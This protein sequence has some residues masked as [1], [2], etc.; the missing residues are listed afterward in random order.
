MKHEKNMNNRRRGAFQLPVHKDNRLTESDIQLSNGV[1]AHL[2]SVW[3]A[4][5]GR[6]TLFATK[7]GEEKERIVGTLLYVGEGTSNNNGADKVF[8]IFF[9]LEKK[10]GEL[11][12]FAGAPLENID[13]AYHP[14]AIE[15]SM[16]PLGIF[17][18]FKRVS[19]GCAKFRYDPFF[20]ISIKRSLPILSERT[21]NFLGNTQAIV[22]DLAMENEI[23]MM[24]YFLLNQNTVNSRVEDF[25]K[26]KYG[27]DARP[28]AVNKPLDCDD[29]GKNM[30]YIQK[31]E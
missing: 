10:N 4:L 9:H 26:E 21:V 27:F 20:G 5:D 18:E 25:F 22:L 11:L 7:T 14:I 16:M 3:N 29:F 1:L 19:E 23:A 2:Y 31:G 17:D 24:P 13:S 30:Y 8:P 15:T 28:I 12:L 6:G